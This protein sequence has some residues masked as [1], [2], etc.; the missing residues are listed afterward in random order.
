MAETLTLNTIFSS[1]QKMLGVEVLEFKRKEDNS[2]G[3]EKS[4]CL[5]KN[6]FAG[7]GRNYGTQ[8]R[9]YSIVPA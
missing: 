8:N 9:L 2:N 4:K 5:V 7:P 1:R 6:T 3:A